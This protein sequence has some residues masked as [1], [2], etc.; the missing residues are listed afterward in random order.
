MATTTKGAL[1]RVKELYANRDAR[2]KELRA[3]GQKAFGYYCCYS[4]TE[5]M[6]AAGIVPYRIMGDIHQTTVEAFSNIESN[7]C[8]YIASCFEMGLNGR[9]DHLDG[10]LV[11]HTCDNVQRIYNFW[12]YY[13]QRNQP[14]E[15][16][17]HYMNVPHV[18]HPSS[19]K[20][21][22]NEIVAFK[23]AVEEYTGEEITDKK[24]KEAIELHNENR[25]LIHQLYDLRKSDP[26]LLRG[27]E[28]TEIIVAGMSVPVQ[29]F[30][31]LLRDVIN[32]IP[33][34]KD[35]PEKK[36]ARLL[37]Y[38]SELDDNSFLQVIEEGGANVVMDDLCIG[39][40]M[41]WPIVDVTDD[42]LDGLTNRYLDQIVCPRTFRGYP[43]TREQDLDLR[44]GYLKQ[45]ADEFKVNGI[46]L[47]ILSF[48]DIHEF[49]VPD[50][51]DYFQ[52]FGLPV[53][54]IEDDYTMA[55]VG[56]VKT[57]VQAFVEMI[58]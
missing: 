33:N 8:P 41:Y 3:Q 29:E 10:I 30:N 15:P 46:V 35:G 12:K 31:Q 34:R 44:F 42:P 9:Y 49:N 2:V 39:S 36:A 43:D 20:F 28:V 13:I 40:R 19:H 18:I 37:V 50:M 27:S 32:E 45:Y 51:R 22:R 26:P 54:H 16:F 58:R 17:A 47:Y 6:T 52:K 14:G 11:P 23:K 1:E 25:K 55:A 24:L 57:R 48:C 56:Q 7:F 38:G 4:P 53:L 5:F 21:F